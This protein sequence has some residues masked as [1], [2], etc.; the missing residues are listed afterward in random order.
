MF[1]FEEVESQKSFSPIKPGCPVAVVLEKAEV[2]ESGDLDIYFKGTD[3]SNSGNFKPRFWANNL[4]VNGDNY[5]DDSA[6]NLQK[7]IK[8]LLEAF[9]DNDAISKIKGNSVAEWFNNIAIALNRADKDIAT[10][11]KIIYKKGDDTNC[12]LPRFGAFISTSFRPLGLRLNDKVGADGIPYDRILPM[13]EYGVE[14]DEDDIELTIED[15]T[16]ESSDLPF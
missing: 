5:N 3:V 12:V 15:S 16:G 11:M 8:Q 6:K 1:S 4:D 13:S 2:S 10:E 14:P 9:L 7:Q